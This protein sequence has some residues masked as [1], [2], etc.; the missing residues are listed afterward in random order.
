MFKL[1]AFIVLIGDLVKPGYVWVKK[2]I[3]VPVS[4][5]PLPYEDSDAFGHMAKATGDVL[6]GTSVYNELGCAVGGT[7]TQTYY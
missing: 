3:P 7:T 5:E 6:V 1:S 2:M 4:K